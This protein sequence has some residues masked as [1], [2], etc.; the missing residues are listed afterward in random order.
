MKTTHD[1]TRTVDLLAEHPFLAD[2]PREWLDRLASHGHP[3]T[4]QPGRRLF[5][6]GRAADRFWLVRSGRIALD[7]TD[8][9]RGDVVVDYIGAGSVLGWSWLFPPYRWHFG[10]VA[11]ELTYTVE[12]D[13][14]GV[15]RLIADDAELGRELTMRFMAVLADR[16]Q[17]TRQRIAELYAPGRT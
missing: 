14:A 16:L 6:E 3:S 5:H 15:R 17:T 7:I 13:A 4:R 11:V 1:V 10:A 8:A 9:H 12:L 2:L